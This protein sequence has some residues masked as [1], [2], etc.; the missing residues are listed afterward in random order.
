MAIFYDRTYDKVITLTNQN[1][2]VTILDT[3][4]KDI[5]RSVRYVVTWEANTTNETLC[6]EILV[7]H[8][9]TNVALTEFGAVSPT[10]RLL[11]FSV[12]S[13]ASEILLTCTI[14]NDVTDSNFTVRRESMKLINAG[15][16]G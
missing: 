3:L 13:N 1:A 16:V 9:G 4:N 14:P 8:D 2:G 7:I 15:L 12:S 5:F 6:T 11:P 10:G